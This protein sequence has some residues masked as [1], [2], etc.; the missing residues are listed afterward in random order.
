MEVHHHPDLHHRKKHFK[1]YFLEGFMIFLAVMLGFFAES[2][3]EYLGDRSREKEYMRSM[4]ADLHQDTANMN[5]AIRSLIYEVNGH[6]SL[7]TMLDCMYR[8]NYAP[9]SG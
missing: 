7:E 2:Y 6:D 8:L 5:M 1:E 9:H 4:L 3:R